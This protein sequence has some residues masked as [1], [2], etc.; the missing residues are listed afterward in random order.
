[1]LKNYLSQQWEHGCVSESTAY[2]P[3]F[4]VLLSPVPYA[5]HVGVEKGVSVVASGS[6]KRDLKA[7]IL[8]LASVAEICLWVL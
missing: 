2:V 5:Q 6:F 3:C 7:S 1:M 4:Q 8:V